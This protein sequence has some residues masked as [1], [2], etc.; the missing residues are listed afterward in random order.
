MEKGRLVAVLATALTLPNFV[1]VLT[2]V[3]YD[4]VLLLT[5]MYEFWYFMVVSAVSRILAG[6]HFN[7]VRASIVLMPWM[8]NLNSALADAN[9]RMARNTIFA[10]IVGIIVD[11]E[12]LV[13]VRLQVIDATRNFT[14]VSYGSRSLGRKCD[15]ERACHA[16]AV[17][18]SECLPTYQGVQ[19]TA[20]TQQQLATR[21]VYQL[22][23]H[24][25]VPAR[26]STR[27][28][29]ICC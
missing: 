2:T 13:C 28:S 20:A 11:C 22:P 25:E 7:G 24:H 19:A 21:R 4:I 3:R 6:L 29:T 17:A 12:F 10:S 15:R 5:K 9:V 26:S 23:L 8:G 27:H 1:V 16:H 14:I 18:L